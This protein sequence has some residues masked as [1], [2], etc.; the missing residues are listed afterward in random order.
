[1]LKIDEFLSTLPNQI[2]S[3]KEITIPDNFFRK[4]FYFAELNEDDVFYYVGVGNNYNSLSIAK[5]EF[6]VKKTV[7]INLTSDDIN[8]K[9]SQI[10]INIGESIDAKKSGGDISIINTD[11]LNISFS[12]ATV[13]FSW[14]TDEKIN[15]LLVSKYLTE[16]HD[17]SKI[18]SIW[19]PPDLFIPCKVDFP[20]LLC[21]KPFI[22]GSDV[23]DQL[24]SIYGSDCIDFTASW[25]MAEKYINSFEI[26]E[27]HHARF[28][29]MLNSLIIWFNARELGLVCEDDIPP[30]VSSYVGIL[31]Y[32]FDIDLT[33][34]IT[35]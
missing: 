2:L 10:R 26:V 13:I 25:R 14:F 32:F 15:D 28:L 5:N 19:S 16:L 22:L 7:G 18:I 30:P 23:K 21:K 6:H 8:H 1:M 4:L 33:E 27:S 35:K 12:Q 3:G 9:N 17:N 20:L 34:F 29:N 11:L 31:K 24:R